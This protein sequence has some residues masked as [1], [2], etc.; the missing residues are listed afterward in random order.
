MGRQ[1]VVKYAPLHSSLVN[2]PFSLYG[3][4]VSGGVVRNRLL[5]GLGYSTDT[6][7]PRDLNLLPFIC[8]MASREIDSGPRTWVGPGWRLRPRLRAGLNQV[9]RLLHWTRLK[10]IR[11]LPL[12]L[13]SS[14]V[15]L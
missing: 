12:V 7:L 15:T 11:S 10:S 8:P 1:V 5:P 9:V 2:L 3:P 6:M 14:R 13:G 4:L